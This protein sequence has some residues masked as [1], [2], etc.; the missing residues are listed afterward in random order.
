MSYI[1][2]FALIAVNLCIGDYEIITADGEFTEN[3]MIIDSAT[4]KRAIKVCDLKYFV[5]HDTIVV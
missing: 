3:G 1:L 5:L 4:L 2:R